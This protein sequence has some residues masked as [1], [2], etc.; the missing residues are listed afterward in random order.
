M[1]MISKFIKKTK[2]I[3]TIV[4]EACK[5]LIH[6]PFTVATILFLVLSFS[7]YTWYFSLLALLF[8]PA[9][10]LIVKSEEEKQHLIIGIFCGVLLLSI[11]F[12]VRNIPKMPYI[13]STFS[14]NSYNDISFCQKNKMK[15][16]S[17]Y[18]DDVRE[19]EYQI[20]EKHYTSDSGSVIYD[21]AVASL[22]RER[23]L[24]KYKNHLPPL[25]K[26]FVIIDTFDDID[27]KAYRCIDKN[28]I[29][30]LVL[31]YD[32]ESWKE[33][34]GSEKFI[35]LFWIYTL[36]FSFLAIIDKYKQLSKVK[37]IGSSDAKTCSREHKFEKKT[38]YNNLQIVTIAEGL[39]ERI[40]MKHLEKYLQNDFD[41]FYPLSLESNNEQQIYNSINK[42]LNTILDYLELPKIISLKVI[43]DDTDTNKSGEYKSS[44]SNKTITVNIKST[45][46][47]KNVKAIVCHECAHYF[48]EYYNLNIEDTQLNEQRTDVMAILLGF[49]SIMIAGYSWNA[50]SD[51]SVIRSSKV[52]YISSDDCL[53]AKNYL[54]EYRKILKEREDEQKTISDSKNKLKKY[55]ETAQTLYNQILT[56]DLKNA[57]D[58]SNASNSNTFELLQKAVYEYE[59]FDVPKEIEKHVKICQTADSIPEINKSIKSMERLCTNMIT[60]LSFFK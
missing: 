16:I 50:S 33:E 53:D 6:S 13:F 54:S 21:Y 2:T 18:L 26:A 24:C 40:Y 30:N 56:V 46:K 10:W 39:C 35:A 36:I 27:S 1:S 60:L 14:V 44:F 32:E 17:V 3:M 38:K 37:T 22:G 5:W 11:F 4:F 9:V 52:G 47:D 8:A 45:Y 23:I 41:V 28:L 15:A 48:M 57:F 29:N 25:K 58:F 59:S 19:T 49:G 55:C 51:G 42:F 34:K 12:N 20:I 7:P 31:I 43:Y